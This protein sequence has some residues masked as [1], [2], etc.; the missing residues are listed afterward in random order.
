MKNY[1]YIIITEIERTSVQV[2]ILDPTLILMFP[3]SGSR[4]FFQKLLRV[5]P[6][7]EKRKK[8]ASTLDPTLILK[9][10]Q[11]PDLEAFSKNCYVS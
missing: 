4:S 2:N 1:T 6:S 5:T 10:F 3:K 9:C 7:I 8:N 11:S